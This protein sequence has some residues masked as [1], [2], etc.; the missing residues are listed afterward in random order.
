MQAGES[1][2]WRK[3]ML[4]GVLSIDERAAKLLGHGG[5]QCCY[6]DAGRQFRRGLPPPRSLCRTHAAP[7]RL[8]LAHAA[9]A[10]CT[11]HDQVP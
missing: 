8:L 1:G 9:Q 7:G 4:A 11:P 10:H 6:R 2:G 3:G 5:G